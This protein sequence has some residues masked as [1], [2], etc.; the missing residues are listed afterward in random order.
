MLT[1][2][3]KFSTHQGNSFNNQKAI[4]V[5]ELAK[6]SIYLGKAKDARA[7]A[8]KSSIRLLKISQDH[9]L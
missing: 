6:N 8:I 5:L 3:L 4:E 2:Y 7:I 9:Y 1:G